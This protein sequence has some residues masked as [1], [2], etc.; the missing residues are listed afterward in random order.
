MTKTR[1]DLHIN[2]QQRTVVDRLLA[3]C[4]Y[5]ATPAEVVRFGFLEYCRLNGV[6]SSTVAGGEVGSS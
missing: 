5:G 4:R 1:I 2:H 3:S 6:E